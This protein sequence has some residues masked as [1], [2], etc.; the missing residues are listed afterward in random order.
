MTNDEEAAE[1][2]LQESK[3]KHRT[4]T[5]AAPSQDNEGQNRTEAIKSAL[6]AIEAGDSPENINVRDARLKALLVGLEEA[7]ELPEIAGTLGEV[8]DTDTDTSDVTQSDVARLLMRVGLQE[9]LP[10]VYEDATKARRQAV[11]EQTD[12][13]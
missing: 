2:L 3:Q 9:T 1:E 6:L 11:L 4:N 10:E 13:F 7:G 5:E 8:L 12:D